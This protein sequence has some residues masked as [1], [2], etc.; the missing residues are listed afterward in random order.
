MSQEINKFV[1]E[2]GALKKS[3]GPEFDEVVL[4]G[5]DLRV[6]SGT[7]IAITGSSGS[8][9]TTLL[10]II[11]GLDGPDA[12]EVS[13][14]GQ[15]LAELN[16][17]EMCKFRN[18]N[19]GFVF[20]F[21]NLLSEFTAVENIAMPLMIAGSPRKLAVDQALYLMDKVGLVKKRADY[22][23]ICLG[24]SVKESRSASYCYESNLS[25]GR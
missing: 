18:Q 10:N 23:L 3:Y 15:L 19:I 5:L 4:Q 6:K 9:K 17:S 8:G 14:S 25:I 20:Q 22:R 24:A 12:G 1:V 7:S 13:V 11:A 2:C 16:S 21:H